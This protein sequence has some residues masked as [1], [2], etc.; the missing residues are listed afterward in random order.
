MHAQFNNFLF[1]LISM[2]PSRQLNRTD[3]W[4]T[5]RD[6]GYL[7]ICLCMLIESNWFLTTNSPIDLVQ[8]RWSQGETV[9]KKYQLPTLTVYVQPLPS[10]DIWFCAWRRQDCVFSKSHWHGNSEFLWKDPHG[11]ALWTK[12]YLQGEGAIVGWTEAA[13]WPRATV[14]WLTRRWKSE[15]LGTR[16]T[17][18]T[19]PP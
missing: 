19:G 16:T 6:S 3:T 14:E 5:L 17:V 15:A 9:Y 1:P 4:P 12:E 2:N 7:H 8:D 11:S 13:E 10:Q 18:S